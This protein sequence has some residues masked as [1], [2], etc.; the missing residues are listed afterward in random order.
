[1]NRWDTC[2]LFKTTKIQLK[3]SLLLLVERLAVAALPC[4]F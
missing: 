3:N 1:L 2:H 4:R